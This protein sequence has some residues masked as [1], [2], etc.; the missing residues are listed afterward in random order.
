MSLL[1]NFDYSK[2]KKDK[3]PKSNSLETFKEIKQIDRLIK[4]IKSGSL[5]KGINVM[6]P[7]MCVNRSET[8][9]TYIGHRGEV[10]FLPEKYLKIK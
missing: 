10:G 7:M 1:K 2:F 9:I 6:K 8:L 4:N 3:L 5:V